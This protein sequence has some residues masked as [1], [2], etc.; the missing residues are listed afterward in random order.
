M[1]YLVLLVLLI[2]AAA[3]GLMAVVV[4]Y[5]F[6][7]NMT[8]TARVMP[9][10]R[11]FTMPAGVVPRGGEVVIP[12]EQRDVAAQVPNPVRLSEV[13]VATGRT[14]YRTFCTPCHGPEGKGG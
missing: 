9:G 12:R 5:R 8:E 1:K 11:V 3:G 4:G 6:M 7:D 14:H 2:V 13:S 10:Q